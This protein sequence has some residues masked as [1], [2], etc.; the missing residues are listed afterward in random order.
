MNCNT[1]ELLKT[2]LTERIRHLNAKA[3]MY[4]AQKDYLSAL[5]ANNRKVALLF[6]LTNVIQCQIDARKL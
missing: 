3:L 5:D 6:E 2:G 1:L 4:E